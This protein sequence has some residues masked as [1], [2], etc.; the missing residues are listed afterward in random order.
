MCV[1]HYLC[2]CSHFKVPS[3]ELPV[4]NFQEISFF[5]AVR[6]CKIERGVKSCQQSPQLP[7]HDHCRYLPFT[8]PFCFIFWNAGYF[9][10]LHWECKGVFIERCLCGKSEGWL[11]PLQARKEWKIEKTTYLTLKVT[12]DIESGWKSVRQKH[13]REQVRWDI[14]RNREKASCCPTCLPWG[15][16]KRQR[17]RPI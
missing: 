13:S 9:V 17:E 12:P 15:W 2:P 1:S 11:N 8:H 3:Q 16:T 14:Q 5:C 7:T 10:W 4:A 6:L